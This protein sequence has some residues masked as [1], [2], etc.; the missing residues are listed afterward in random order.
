M[1]HYESIEKGL[2]SPFLLVFS[3]TALPFQASLQRR[4]N[5]ASKLAFWWI[6]TMLS[7]VLAEVLGF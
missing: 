5:P 1:V 3:S 6:C 2:N 4:R 7:E